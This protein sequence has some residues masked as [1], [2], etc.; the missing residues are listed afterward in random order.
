MRRVCGRDARE[1]CVR[2]HGLHTY[3]H[4]WVNEALA[5]LM[6][7]HKWDKWPD[8]VI[9][10]QH[11]ANWG[12]K[13]LVIDHHVPRPSPSDCRFVLTVMGWFGTKSSETPDATSRKD[14]QK[15]WES[16]DVYFGCLDAAKVVKPGDEGTACADTKGAYEQNCAK[17]W[18]R[19][20]A[21]RRALP[22]S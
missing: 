17:S 13:F 2:N 15:C 11:T 16:R 9:T 8:N 12:D 22:L 5:L 14:R 20:P 3:V 21:R 18:V 1:P 10:D 6:Y 19:Y 4:I 7:A